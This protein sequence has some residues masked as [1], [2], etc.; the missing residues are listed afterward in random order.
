MGTRRWTRLFVTE[1]AKAK[2][3][4]GESWVRI[5]SVEARSVDEVRKPHHAATTRLYPWT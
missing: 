4:K 3:Q 2:W 1:T 5:K